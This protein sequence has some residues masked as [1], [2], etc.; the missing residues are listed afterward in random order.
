MKRR[1]VMLAVFVGL[2]MATAASAQSVATRIEDQPDRKQ[3]AI[4]IGPVDLPAMDMSHGNHD[5]ISMMVLPPVATVT[6]PKDVYLHGFDFDVVDAEGKVVPRQVVHHLNLIDP[7]HRELFL[8]I[9]QRVGAIGGETGAQDL[10]TVAK[11]IVG[12]PLKQGQQVVV[13][14]MLHNPT[15]KDIKGATV[16]YYWKYLP[17]GRPWPL[18]GLQP[19]QMDV[20]FPAGDKSFDIPPGESSKSW[21]GKPSVPGRVMV[22]GGHLHELA[23]SL[24]FEDVTNNRLIWEGKPHTDEEGNVNHLAIGYL[25]KTF[26]AK[27]QPENTYRVSVTYVNPTADT[28]KG[29]GMG[30]VAGV[31]LPGDEWPATNLSDSLYV[32]DRRHYMREVRGQLGKLKEI[33][34]AT[35]KH[36]ESKPHKH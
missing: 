22:I 9:S 17:G 8:P 27:V 21:E 15:G 34:A 35:P 24:R 23:T 36:D 13:S 3:L 6:I 2:R 10:G 1:T 25:Y 18:L 20:S 28:L 30:V 19:F 4:L 14:L 32:L 11:Y 29:G 16:R 5:D 26:G 31:F 12:M 33:N 7:G